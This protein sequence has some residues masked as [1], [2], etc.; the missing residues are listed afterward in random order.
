[1]YRHIETTQPYRIIYYVILFDK[2]RI[3]NVEIAVSGNE[4][5]SLMTNRVSLYPFSSVLFHDDLLLRRCHF[6]SICLI[7]LVYLS[8]F[9]VS[10]VFR[11]LL[12]V[13]FFLCSGS[14]VSAF[15]LILTISFLLCFSSFIPRQRNIRSILIIFITYV[16]NYNNI[17]YCKDD[18]RNTL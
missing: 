17:C 3:L 13:W 6:R 16:K 14:T 12:G 2:T 7:L 5:F 11:F 4:C 10:C 1:M 15:L 9:F 18:L 8:C